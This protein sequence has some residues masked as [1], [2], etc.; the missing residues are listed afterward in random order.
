[1]SRA[2]AA[3]LRRELFPGPK[4]APVS[5]SERSRFS[6]PR[7]VPLNLIRTER[8]ADSSKK[9]HAASLQAVH[10]WHLY[11]KHDT[12]R[13]KRSHTHVIEKLANS[14]LLLHSTTGSTGP[15][16]GVCSCNASN[17]T[18][19][20]GFCR[21]SAMVLLTTFAIDSAKGLL[22]VAALRGERRAI[23]ENA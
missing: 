15:V 18:G 11:I 14:V 1:L 22:A 12:V 23:K 9:I 20:P 5:V 17:S 7:P 10:P 8:R 6:S 2:C 3:D 21:Y 13:M 19:G 4:R 16:V